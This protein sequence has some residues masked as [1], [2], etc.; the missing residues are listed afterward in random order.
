MGTILIASPELL[1]LDEPFVG[2][3]A[4]NT[5]RLLDLCRSFLAEA[6]QRSLLVA[7]HDLDQLGDAFPI[8]WHL[9]AGHLEV[10][11]PLARAPAQ[12]L[13]AGGER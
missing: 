6:P 1:V 4:A 5:R 7:T 13:R 2:Q 11:S 12:S 8:H 9:S 3:D 10:R